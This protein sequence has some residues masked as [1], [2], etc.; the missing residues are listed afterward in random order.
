MRPQKL[1]LTSIPEVIPAHMCFTND[2]KSMQ[3]E[4]SNINNFKLCVSLFKNTSSDNIRTTL[5]YTSLQMYT[6]SVLRIFISGRRDSSWFFQTTL[7]DREIIAHAG[8]KIPL[9]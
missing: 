1:D 5:N 4:K 2:N 8:N 7:H 3:S 6:N 9:V